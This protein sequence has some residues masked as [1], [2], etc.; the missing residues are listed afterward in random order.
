MET[1]GGEAEASPVRPLETQLREDVAGHPHCI[2]RQWFLPVPHLYGL[3][4]HPITQPAFRH[5]GQV[6]VSWVFQ[7]NAFTSEV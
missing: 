6:A 3:R 5:A 4:F 1:L 2:W 7:I